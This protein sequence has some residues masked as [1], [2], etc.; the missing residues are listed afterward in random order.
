MRSL[1]AVI[2]IALVLVSGCSDEVDI[3]Q[4]DPLV[5]LENQFETKTLWSV[6]VGDGDD[7]KTLKL[8]PV[9]NYGKIFVADGSGMV[10]AV[11]PAN[12]KLLWQVELDEKLGGGPAVA[13]NLIAVGTQSGQL[14]VLSAEDGSIMWRK[15]VSSEV[16]SAPDI[17]DGAVVVRTVDGKITA[18][19]AEDGEQMWL[20]DQVMPSL[21]LRGESAPVIIGGGVIAGFSNGKIAVFLIQNGRV[22][23]EKT[24]ASPIGHSE[25]QKLVDVDIK[26]LVFGG[27][28]FVAAYNGNLMNIQA[29]NGEII[30]QRELS[31]YQDLSIDELMLLVTHEN[32]HVSAINQTNGELLWTQKS[33]HRRQLTTPVAIGDEVVV[34]DFE[35]YLHWLSR[36]DGSMLSRESI[37][38]AGISAAPLVIDDKIILYS[39]DGTLYA[40]KK[41]K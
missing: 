36:K 32:S 25:I 9:Y 6:S 37:D 30:W 39:H 12:G 29:N 23:W 28:I 38:S 13:N 22:A 27:N 7:D 16:V 24:V 14:I 33:L 4:P 2:V 41:E 5:D 15:D 21:T 11:D 35:G 18:F 1:F 26:P 17:G 10:S 31:S 34:A 8:M 3:Y 40:V 19:N 20:Y